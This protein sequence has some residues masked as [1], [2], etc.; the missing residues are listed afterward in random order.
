MNAGGVS[1]NPQQT[2]EPGSPPDLMYPPQTPVPHAILSLAPLL[3][4]IVLLGTPAR[5][6]AQGGEGLTAPEPAAEGPED[7]EWEADGEEPEADEPG[8]F[9]LDLGAATVFPLLVGGEVTAELP[10]RL[11]AQLDVGWLP[12]GY[13]RAIGGI[14]SAFQADALT[15][16]LLERGL[17]GSPV[18]RVSLGLRPF[19][20]AGLELFGGYSRVALG[21]DISASTV[22]E[23][24]TGHPLPGNDITAH[25][26]STLHALHGTLGWRSVIA[27][28]VVLRFSVGYLRAVGTSTAIRF[29]RP[30]RGFG[31]RRVAEAEDVVDRE[32]RGHTQTVTLQAAVAYRL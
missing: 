15:V 14:A 4:G 31:P 2:P 20:R 9:Q 23:A 11:L 19:K 17:A 3:A 27:D 29:D 22:V 1:I 5:A 10:G 16:D 30:I 7:D 8:A 6:V 25:V 24:V 32:L 18:V 13:A 21:A 28:H 26:S 12:G